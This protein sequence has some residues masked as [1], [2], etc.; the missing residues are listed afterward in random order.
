MSILSGISLLSD[1]TEEEIKNF[2]LFCQEKRIPA[3]ENVFHENDNASAMYIL[4]E[5]NIEIT[6]SIKWW[7]IVLWEVH[8]EEI[9]WEMALFWDRNKRMATAVALTDCTLI[10]ILSFSIN[11]LTKKHP[12]LLEKIKLI[13]NDRLI[14]NKKKIK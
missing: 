1:L 2:S 7:K 14:S 9:L 3:W 10:T 4:K 13:I 11:D 12:E 8:A 6:R 5:G